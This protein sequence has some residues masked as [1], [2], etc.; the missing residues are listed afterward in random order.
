MVVDEDGQ[1]RPAL[2][3]RQVGVTETVPGTLPISSG[4]Q[5]PAKFVDA[6]RHEQDR[7]TK[8]DPPQRAALFEAP[9]A[10]CSSGYRHLASL[11]HFDVPSLRH[12]ISQG[13]R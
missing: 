1:N 9:A 8:V 5:L 11:A 13:K 6:A 4:K 12:A 10:P 2:L 3:V 7:V